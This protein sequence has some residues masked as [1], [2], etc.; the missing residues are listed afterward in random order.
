MAVRLG[1]DLGERRVG[2]ALTDE[3]GIM[4]LP[5]TTFEIRG[6][7]HLLSL[8]QETVKRYGVSEIIIG[9]P[10]TLKGEIGEA[11]KKVTEEAAW[12]ETE[13]GLPVKLWDERL[14][15]QEVERYLQEAEIH[16]SRRKELRDQMAA[17]KILQC[18][19]DSLRIQ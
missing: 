13:L 8:L 12:I 2:V 19:L 4:A 6:R 10:K 15:S 7:K 18:Y 3:A 17:Q 16:Y 11:A 14:T 1:L 5:L 9:L